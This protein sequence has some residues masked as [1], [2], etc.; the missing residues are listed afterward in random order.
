[1]T[2]DG[3]TMNA[4]HDYVFRMSKDQLPPA[5]AFWSITLYDMQNGFFIPNEQKKYNVGENGG[6]ALNAEGGIDIYDAAEQPE[7]VPAENW[8]PLD[9]QDEVL[10]A[11]LRI[12]VPDFEAF[13]IW[14]APPVEI[15]DQLLRGN[16]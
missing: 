6:M 9:R 15:I 4:L 13:Q 7:G 1:V 8:L 14:T 2:K 3:E 5:Q 11:G 16:I 12:H 10:A